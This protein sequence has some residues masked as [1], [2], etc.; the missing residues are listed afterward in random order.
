MRKIIK[1]MKK[2]HWWRDFVIFCLSAGFL[3]AGFILLWAASWDIPDFDSFEERKVAQSTKIYDRTGEVLL[4]DIHQ[5]IKRTVVPYED[6]SRYIKNATVAIED[7]TFYE[8]SGIRPVS[9]IR[10]V[11]ANITTGSL[12]QGGSTITQ[13]VIKNAILTQE[14]KISRKI[15]EWGLSLKLEQVMSK[16]EILEIYL[17]EA[18]YGGSIYG[19]AEASRSFFNKD[20]KEL[21][22][23]E[24]AYLAA[25]PQAPTLYSPYGNNK[26]M[27]EDRKNLVLARMYELGFITQGEYDSAKEEVVEFIARAE[28]GIRAPHFVLYVR[29]YLEKKYGK[30]VVEQGGLKVTT[31]LNYD[32]QEKAEGIV[33]EYALVNEEK[34]NAE[35]ASLV[36]TDPRTGQILVMVGSRDYFDEN[37]DG[38]FNVSIAH[39]Q[40]GS[41]FKPFVYA[42]AFEKGYMPE[43]VIFD[44]PTEF[45]TTCD[46]EGEPKSSETDPDECY[47]PVNYDGI[48]RGPV[49]LRDSLAQSLNVPAVKTLYLAGLRDSLHT[50]KNFGIRSLTN[51]D[52]YGLT[53]VLGGGE[54]S[55]LDITNSYGVFANDG[56]YN[57]HTPILKVEDKSGNTLEEFAT[58]SH[59]VITERTARQISD[60]LSDNEART[61]LYG[62]NSLLY[63]GGMDVAVKTGTTNDYRDAWTIGYTPYISVGA[64]AGN[65]DNSS[66][67]KKISGL[68]ITPLWR[69]FMDEAI[70]AE[71]SKFYFE[72]AAKKEVD[73]M[74]ILRGLWQGGRSYVIDTMSGKLATERTPIETQEER[75]ITDVHN[76]LYWIDKENPLGSQPENPEKDSQFESW[77]Y[78]VRKW[79]GETGIVGQTEDSIPKEF[80]DVH[81]QQTIPS[82]QI[83]QPNQQSLYQSNSRI[84]VNVTSSGTYPIIKLDFYI[85]GVFVG[86]SNRAPFSFSFIPNE[87]LSI[88]NENK[89]RVIAT[90][91]VYNKV[92]SIT[93]FYI[94]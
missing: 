76:I 11:I 16:E 2:I 22:L 24:S 78:S 81:T 45:Q 79:A 27:L 80:D 3:G 89:L 40:P 38:N 66:M 63:F 20:A 15:K 41:A 17:N 21:T 33:N 10:A 70:A 51:T 92:E 46:P 44:L 30:D 48:Y 34:F 13:Q 82:I 68:I 37:I 94:Q 74:P 39:R 35:N 62:A 57:Q 31:T 14:K 72:K 55:L 71:P 1:K 59:S 86:S 75:V 50:A 90:D 12:G 77:E 4:Y 73:V 47:M 56:V 93:N 9:F 64:W 32:L 60:I 58:K 25:L 52:Q 54:V 53:L 28:K 7:D 61:P 91:S 87:I 5:N 23:A 18:P 84:S 65:N 69:S 88:K 6:I 83:T 43:T 29:A 85:N 42:T 36:A 19:V 67:D 26:D 8:H 49:N